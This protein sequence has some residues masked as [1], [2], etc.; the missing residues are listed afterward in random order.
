MDIWQQVV[1]KIIQTTCLLIMIVA[2]RFWNIKLLIFVCFVSWFVN[3]CQDNLITQISSYYTHFH[4]LN[5]QIIKLKTSLGMP[6][7]MLIHSVNKLVESIPWHFMVYIETLQQ[8]NN[9]FSLSSRHSITWWNI[10]LSGICIYKIIKIVF[11]ISKSL[12]Q[13]GMKILILT[14]NNIGRELLEIKELIWNAI[15]N[16]HLDPPHSPVSTKIIRFQWEIS[17]LLVLIWRVL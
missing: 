12:G 17:I 13:S 14:F 16:V 9:Y 7:L 6:C 10:F 8:A 3:N 11:I 4:K 1:T 2:S 5:K 15:H